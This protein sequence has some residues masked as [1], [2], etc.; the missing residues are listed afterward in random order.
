MVL[1]RD[2]S[3]ISRH[4]HELDIFAA[5]NSQGGDGEFLCLLADFS[6]LPKP[7]L[8]VDLPDGYSQTTVYMGLF[9]LM[10]LCGYLMLQGKWIGVHFVIGLLF[11]AKLYFTSLNYVEFKGNYDYYHNIYCLLFI[12]SPH[13]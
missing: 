13:K 2:S 12:V 8:A 9:G 1:R 6:E 3:G 5:H 7:D 11:L 10:A 4:V